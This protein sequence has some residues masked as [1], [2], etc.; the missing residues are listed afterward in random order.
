M[1]YFKM[2]QV[3]STSSWC[4]RRRLYSHQFNKTYIQST[5]TVSKDIDKYGHSLLFLAP[6][7]KGVSICLIIISIKYPIRYTHINISLLYQCI[8]LESINILNT[9]KPTH[10]HT[11]T[12]TTIWQR[13]AKIMIYYTKYLGVIII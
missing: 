1:H 2:V 8:K 5:N 13:L 9:D 11:N 7:S 12:H 6:S 4:N 10:T 3:F